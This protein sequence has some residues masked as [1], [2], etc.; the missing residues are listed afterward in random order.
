MWNPLR[1]RSIVK[2]DGSLERC[3]RDPV[4]AVRLLDSQMDAQ[5]IADPAD[6]EAGF[7]DDAV[8]VVVDAVARDLSRRQFG[9]V[10]AEDPPSGVCGPEITREHELPLV[11]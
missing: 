10:R 1:S 3:T 5:E 11:D 6:V 4:A 7:V 2:H 8:P 9:N